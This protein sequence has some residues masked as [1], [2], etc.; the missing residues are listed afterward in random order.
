MSEE[1]R[2]P[3]PIAQGLMRFLAATGTLACG[4]AVGMGAYAM[5]SGLT[6]QNHQR[7]GLAALFLF[8]H[9]LAL[10]ALAPGTRSR[11]Q[12][13]GLCVLLI[14]TILFAGSL[15]FAAVAGIEPTLAPYGGSLLIVGWLI[16]ATGFLFG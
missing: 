6:S 2:A 5:H 3:E 11:M 14:G 13:V 10:A 16:I 9:G 8:A 15:A 1:R 12:R 4:A 7:M